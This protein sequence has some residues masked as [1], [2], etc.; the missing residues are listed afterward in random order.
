MFVF[1]FYWVA[2]YDHGFVFPV[3]CYMLKGRVSFFFFLYY[4]KGLSIWRRS[5]GFF[6]LVGLG[7]VRIF[8]FIFL[9][10]WRGG[11]F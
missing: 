11:E 4:T 9:L 3:P 10:E 2:F 7:I 1:F 5:Y 8:Y 6:G